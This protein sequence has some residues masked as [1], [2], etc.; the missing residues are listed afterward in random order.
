MPARR[1]RRYRDRP[2][3]AP[4][5]PAPPLAQTPP[6]VYVSAPSIPVVVEPGSRWAPRPVGRVIRRRAGMAYVFAAL[7]VFLCLAV[8]LAPGPVDAVTASFAALGAFVC[9]GCVAAGP[10]ARFVVSA[11]HLEIRTAVRIVVAALAAVPPEHRAEDFEVEY[12]ARF[13]MIALLVVSGAALFAAT[14]AVAR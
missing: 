11:R 3:P 13:W 10:V 7:G 9:V 1:N 4:P 2:L 14:L 8:V 12:I 6:P 5:A